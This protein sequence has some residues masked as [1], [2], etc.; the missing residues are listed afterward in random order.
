VELILVFGFGVFAVWRV[1]FL[2]TF[3]KPLWVPKRHQEIQLAHRAKTPKPKT[4][5]ICLCYEQT[6]FVNT[7]VIYYHAQSWFSEYRAHMYAR[8]PSGKL[9][10]FSV[11]TV[12]IFTLP[13][14]TQHYRIFKWRNKLTLSTRQ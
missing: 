3:W 6:S 10:G 1:N 7:T 4:K 11:I 14:H 8:K 9:S 2:T 5:L 12:Y 13:P